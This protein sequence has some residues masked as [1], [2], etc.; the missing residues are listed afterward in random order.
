MNLQRRLHLVG[1]CLGGLPV[2][3]DVGAIAIAGKR[4]DGTRPCRWLGDLRDMQVAE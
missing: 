1:L 2:T 4:R 3:T